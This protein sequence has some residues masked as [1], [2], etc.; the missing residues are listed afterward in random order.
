[1]PKPD[2]SIDYRAKINLFLEMEKL[3]LINLAVAKGISETVVNQVMEE[4]N[5]ID[6]SLENLQAIIKTREQE[7]TAQAKTAS[8]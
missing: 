4:E 6:F 7:D 2:G 3:K 8:K 1:M 5:L